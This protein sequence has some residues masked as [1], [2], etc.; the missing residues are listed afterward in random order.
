M[1]KLRLPEPPGIQYR[2]EEGSLI[3]ITDDE[4]LALGIRSG[5]VW[6]LNG[7]SREQPEWDLWVTL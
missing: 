6:E 4:D 5:N 1:E 7:T 3:L 2:D